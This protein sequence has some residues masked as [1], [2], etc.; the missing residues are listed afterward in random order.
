MSSQTTDGSIRS[1]MSG[2]TT[3]PQ[4]KCQRIFVGTGTPTDRSHGVS[5]SVCLFV[6]GLKKA[7]AEGKQCHAITMKSKRSW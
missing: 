3:T 6:T 5:E 1:S 2:E 7:K 4:K